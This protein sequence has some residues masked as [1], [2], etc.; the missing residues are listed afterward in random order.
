M[1]VL[2]LDVSMD[3]LYIV[4]AKCAGFVVPAMMVI[5]FFVIF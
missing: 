2:D 5:L 4:R 3:V 1:N